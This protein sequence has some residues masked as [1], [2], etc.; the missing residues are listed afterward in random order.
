MEIVEGIGEVFTA[1]NE[2]RKLWRAFVKEERWADEEDWGPVWPILQSDVSIVFEQKVW[3][4]SVWVDDVEKVICD[5][6]FDGFRDQPRWTN[7][8]LRLE[9][10]V[11]WTEKHNN[12]ACGSEAVGY[13]RL[14]GH[15]DSDD[16]WKKAGCLNDSFKSS[17]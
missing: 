10:V 4:A 14:E 3:P 1:D 17:A 16:C 13:V 5:W 15:S 11:R 6:R 8:Q 7:E 12:I 2:M 9:P